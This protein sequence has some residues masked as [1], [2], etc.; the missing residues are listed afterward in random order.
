MWCFCSFLWQLALALRIRQDKVDETLKRVGLTFEEF[1]Q[2]R[3]KKQ[4][5]QYA[6]SKPV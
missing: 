3:L 5:E 6:L 2:L 4:H 1:E